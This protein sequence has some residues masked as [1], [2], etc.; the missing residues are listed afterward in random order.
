[1]KLSDLSIVRVCVEAGIVYHSSAL[2]PLFPT[3]LPCP[4]LE[5]SL[6]SHHYMCA[7]GASMHLHRPLHSLHILIDLNVTCS[8]PA[9]IASTYTC[10][11]LPRHRYWDHLFTI[12]CF[13]CFLRSIVVSRSLRRISHVKSNIEGVDPHVPASIW[14]HLHQNWGFYVDFIVPLY[15]TP[16]TRCRGVLC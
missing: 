16:S 14:T 2:I 4:R 11:H 8:A 6:R 7:T 12:L 9:S 15:H 1:M 13:D 10:L 3:R 5:Y